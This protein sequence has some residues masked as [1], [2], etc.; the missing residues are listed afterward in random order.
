CDGPTA[1]CVSGGKNLNPPVPA[2]SSFMPSMFMIRSVGGARGTGAL[3]LAAPAAAAA[4]S[5]AAF[6]ASYS[7]APSVGIHAP[8]NASFDIGD[9]GPLA[10]SACSISAGVR[11]VAC[12]AV[13][14]PVGG[15]SVSTT[16][17]SLARS[18]DCAC[19]WRLDGTVAYPRIAQRPTRPKNCL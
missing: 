13:I 14:R 12:L 2:A 3:D 5:A 1:P 11:S 7:P 18:L 10:A 19:A 8:S 9:A 4:A 6:A 16:T 17:D 15:I